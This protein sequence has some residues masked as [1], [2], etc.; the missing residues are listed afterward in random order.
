[1]LLIF[2]TCKLWSI[3]PQELAVVHAG[4]THHFMEVSAVRGH[5]TKMLLKRNKHAADECLLQ[6]KSSSSSFRWSRT[7]AANTFAAQS[8]CPSNSATNNSVTKTG[9]SLSNIRRKKISKPFHLCLCASVYVCLLLT[10]K[11]QFYLSSKHCFS[12]HCSNRSLI[13]CLPHTLSA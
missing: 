7:T 1:M 11:S 10:Q 8:R 6:I 5:R 2:F 12:K 3:G 9:K 4:L 13:R